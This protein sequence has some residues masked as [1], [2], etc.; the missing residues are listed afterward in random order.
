MTNVTRFAGSVPEKY[1]RYMGPIFFEPYAADLV[2]RLHASAGMRVL[3]LA[4][5]T[6]IVTR[7]LRDVLPEDA[8]LVATDLNEGMIKQAVRKFGANERIEWRQADATDLPFSDEAFDAVICQFGVMFFPNKPAA[9]RQASG[10]PVS[11][12]NPLQCMGCR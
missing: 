11:R 5:G 4:C 2:N 3:E 9:F 7:R 8:T 1:D 12:S 6:G 10:S